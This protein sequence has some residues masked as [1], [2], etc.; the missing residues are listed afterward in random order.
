VGIGALPKR[1]VLL[2][3]RKTLVISA[4][5]FAER[6]MQTATAASSGRLTIALDF[7][8]YVHLSFRRP[9]LG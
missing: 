6:L 4:T 2:V 8:D 3:L 7:G 5:L 9:R 1:G